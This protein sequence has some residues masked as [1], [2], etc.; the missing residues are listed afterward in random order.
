MSNNYFES[1]SFEVPTTDP[2]VKKTKYS[3]SGPKDYIDSLKQ[4][5]IEIQSTQNY[6]G[7]SITSKGYANGVLKSTAEKMIGT[8]T[9]KIESIV[10]NKL[11]KFRK[12]ELEEYDPYN[13]T[14]DVISYIESYD[15]QGKTD[16]NFTKIDERSDQPYERKYANSSIVSISD[17]LRDS[18]F[19]KML[20]KIGDD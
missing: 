9:I 10:S 4:K 13:P 15:K 12:I 18:E 6:Q 2:N 14:S 7:W 8:R 16:P 11:P 20:H 17:F 5:P 1:Y 3:F 19:E